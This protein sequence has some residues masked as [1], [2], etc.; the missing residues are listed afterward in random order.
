MELDQFVVRNS[1]KYFHTQPHFDD[2]RVQ[3]WFGDGAKSLLMLPKSYFGSF[4]LIVIDLSETVMSF[5]VTDKLSIF[6]TLSLLLKPEGIM[7][8][9][10]EY[11]MDSMSSHFDYTLQYFEYDVPFICDQGM[12]I[13]S[14]NLDFFN[15]TGM[16]DH[17]V[18]TYVYEPQ[19]KIL[20]T[21][22]T[23]HRFTEYR[24]N[25]AREQGQCQKMSDADIYDGGERKQA[26]ILMVVEGE[27]LG[28]SSDITIDKES[29]SVTLKSVGLTPLSTVVDVSSDGK[30][31]TII[32]IMEEG[33]ITARI[34]PE[35]SYCAL[36]IQLW[37]GFQLMDDTKTALIASFGGAESSTSSFRLVDGGMYGSSTAQQDLAIIGPRIA[38]TRH[39]DDDDDDDDDDEI[40][41][42]TCNDES[43]TCTN[44][45][46]AAA[47]RDD[48]E[49][50]MIE[51]A[52]SLSG[53]TENNNAVVAVICGK[54]GQSCKTFDVLKRSSSIKK[55]LPLYTCPDS[56]D[57][58][59]CEVDTF[60]TLL[61]MGKLS[62][63]I[64]D[65]SV[66]QVMLEILL[67]IFGD[68][69]NRNRLITSDRFSI[70]VPAT[71]PTEG[72]V[73]RKYNRR[74]FLVLVRQE[75]VYSPM[76]LADVVVKTKGKTT[77]GPAVESMSILSLNDSKFF[78]NLHGMVS[79]F[80]KRTATAK[81]IMEVKS[82]YD[83]L[84]RPQLGPFRPKIFKPDDYDLSAGKEQLAGQKSLGRQSLYQF[85][86]TNYQSVPSV[87]LPSVMTN[88]IFGMGWTVKQ[89]IGQYVDGI[90]DGAVFVGIISGGNVVVVWDGKNHIDVNLFTLDDNEQLR[91]KFS[92]QFLRHLKMETRGTV[93]L[94]LSDTHPRG[95]GRV[96]SFPK[97][98]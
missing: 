95:T 83:G 53:E 44:P 59:D 6:Q 14:N 51:E 82:V 85:D 86:I 34:W 77:T 38:N 48:T 22:G 75:V 70:V 73:L 89:D 29:I 55:I 78:N 11:Y 96:V 7:L 49:K 24:K 26:G 60:K 79:N 21:N 74:N 50:I 18:E 47:N 87:A 43:G 69:W 17:G 10:G 35:L 71:L 98:N 15:S 54:K 97:G 25:N 40:E 88:S 32:V 19:D 31:S 2:K 9:N 46:A 1:F 80:N 4:D 13:G 84:V 57:L 61:N 16:K 94:A 30:V 92:N 42:N 91:S 81:E 63:L 56:G 33:Y 45:D 62:L 23:F 68:V 12:V 72:Q 64:I 65:T 27:K 58:T 52:L 90:G 5:Q 20:D 76:T 3:W 67:S 93:T 39:C 28:E 37:G 36:D 8:K 66:E 41:A